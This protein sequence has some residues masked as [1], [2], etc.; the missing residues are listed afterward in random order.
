MNTARQLP[1]CTRSMFAKT[2]L[3]LTLI[4]SLLCVTQARSAADSR[5]VQMPSCAAM[6][7]MKPCCANMPC[8][9]TQPQHDPAPEQAP[10]PSRG[11]MELTVIAAHTFSFLYALSAPARRFV[12][13]DEARAAHTLPPLAATCIRLI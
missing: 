3:I 7:C 1:V 6:V 8:C 11:G 10:A 2:S 4:V 13:R 5:A 9:A 12:I